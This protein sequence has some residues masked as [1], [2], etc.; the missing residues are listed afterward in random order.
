M[1]PKTHPQHGIVVATNS[2]ALWVQW[3]KPFCTPT[4]LKCMSEHWFQ[5]RLPLGLEQ[6]QL[7]QRPQSIPKSHQSRRVEAVGCLTCASKLKESGVKF[8]I[9]CTS[10]GSKIAEWCDA[11]PFCSFLYPRI[12][13]PQLQARMK[14]VNFA[15]PR[16]ISSPR[17]TPQSHGPEAWR[18]RVLTSRISPALKSNSF[19][20]TLFK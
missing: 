4:P 3:S 11:V 7:K 6:V 2:L 18:T 15:P 19:M 9:Y 12:C 16:K 17:A 5:H 10:F 13:L 8:C 14:H 20:G 1:R